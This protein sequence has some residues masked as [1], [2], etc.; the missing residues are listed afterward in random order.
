MA[1]LTPGMKVLDTGETERVKDG[2]TEHKHKTYDYWHPVARVH[3]ENR[4]PTRNIDTTR[5]MWDVDEDGVYDIIEAVTGRQAG[6]TDLFGRY[7]KLPL[8]CEIVGLPGDVLSA[9][10]CVSLSAKFDIEVMMSIRSGHLGEVKISPMQ[11]GDVRFCNGQAHFEEGSMIHDAKLLLEMG[12]V[13]MYV[14]NPDLAD[15]M[16]IL[17]ISEGGSYCD[18]VRLMNGGHIPPEIL[19]REYGVSWETLAKIP[20]GKPR[21]SETFACPICGEPAFFAGVCRNCKENSDSEISQQIADANETRTKR[22]EYEHGMILRMIKSG[23]WSKCRY[24]RYEGAR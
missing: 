16:R 9:E 4:V 2:C 12:I 22:K 17:H 20:L 14:D 21:D 19:I 11:L 8:V 7:V 15:A 6:Y 13:S 23:N 5:R 1:I 24:M 3:S 10:W 18:L